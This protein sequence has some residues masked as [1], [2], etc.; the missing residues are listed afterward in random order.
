MQT[1][2]ASVIIP[3]YN[4]CEILKRC[5]VALFN[6]TC[7]PENY[8]IIIVD[9]GSTDG[10]GEMVESVRADAP[11][12]VRYCFKKHAGIAAARNVGVRAARGGLIIFIDN[13]IMTGPDFV[14]SHVREHTWDLASDNLIVHGPVIYTI[15]F[16]N[17]TNERQKLTEISAAFFAGGNVS[18]ARERL[19]EAGLFDEDFTEYGWEDLELG[20]RLKKLGMRVVRSRDPKGYHFKEKFTLDK[21]PLLKQKE[22]ER[23]RMA[24]LYYEK[25]PTSRVRMAT[26]LI[27]PFFWLDRIIAFGNWGE[28]RITMAFLRFL[29][30]LKCWP[31]L[32]CIVRIITYHSYAEGMR[33]ALRARKGFSR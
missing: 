7:P 22:V 23:G 11:C 6:Q 1:I 2:I 5:L 27:P 4:R 17:P 19:V 24:V 8:E 9:D 26:L 33:E 20:K 12:V 32:L 21:L 16:E 14:E 13:D 18:I 30:R 10:T 3:T 25:H 29:E 31:L 15:D 28:W